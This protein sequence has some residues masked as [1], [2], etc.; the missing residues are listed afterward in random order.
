MTDFN[1]II[2]IVLTGMGIVFAM[3]GTVIALFLWNCGEANADRR[4]IV[5]LIICI[6]EDAAKFREDIQKEVQAI[7][8]EMKDF[9][10]KLIIIEEKRKN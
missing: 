3:V 6:K 2:T 7:Q 9:H 10:N 1:L 5:N 8:L 4:D